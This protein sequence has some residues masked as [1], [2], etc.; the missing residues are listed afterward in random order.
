MSC[1]ELVRRPPLAQT[2]AAA[3]DVYCTARSAQTR[4]VYLCEHK[5]RVLTWMNTQLL[6]GQTQ[7][8]WLPEQTQ[9][10]DVYL[11]EDK[12]SAYLDKHKHHWT[13]TDKV[14]T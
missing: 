12:Q 3:S 13:N 5:Q 7:T 10:Q 1:C 4:D 14:V 11:D 6:P 9:T 8:R 2:S